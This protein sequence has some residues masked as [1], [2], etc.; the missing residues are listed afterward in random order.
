LV[1]FGI[2]YSAAALAYLNAVKDVGSEVLALMPIPL[3]IVGCF[4]T[5]AVALLAA[6]GGSAVR[7]E[8]QLVDVVGL[9]G[10][11]TIEA[12]KGW[13]QPEQ[14]DRG[15]GIGAH[16]GEQIL[17]PNRVSDLSVGSGFV[18]GVALAGVRGRGLQDQ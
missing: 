18:G 5:V 12:S 2:A 15:I 6:H 10:F 14:W 16:V 13:V 1:G 4:H 17:D 3:A 8:K 7:L 11:Y 9:K